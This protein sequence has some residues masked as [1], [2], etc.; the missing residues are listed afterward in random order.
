MALG[1]LYR[2]GYR[3]KKAGVI[4]LDLMP[5]ADV[6][7]GLFDAPD[8]TNRSRA[9]VQDVQPCSSGWQP[10]PRQQGLDPTFGSPGAKL[11]GGR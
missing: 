8:N 9:N 4:L 11:A 10:L 7:A 1:A 6:P 2:P 3:Y 5:A